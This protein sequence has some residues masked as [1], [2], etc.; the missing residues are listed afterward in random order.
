MMNLSNLKHSPIPIS[1]HQSFIVSSAKWGLVLEGIKHIQTIAG[2]IYLLSKV[3]NAI[4][5]LLITT[6]CIVDPML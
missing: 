1:K 2:Q 4:S 5:K 6:L 3:E